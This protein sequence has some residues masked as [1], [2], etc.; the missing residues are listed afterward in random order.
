MTRAEQ[1][2]KLGFTS[3]DDYLASAWWNDF[4][5]AYYRVHRGGCKVCGTRVILQLHHTTYR[6][7]GCESFDDVVPLCKPHHGSVHDWIR[8]HGKSISQTSE[9]ID[10][11]RR[12]WRM[13][14]SLSAV[15]LR[16]RYE[17][18]LSEFTDLMEITGGHVK[19]PHG[20]EP[21]FHN[22]LLVRKYLPKLR[23]A[24]RKMRFLHGTL[25]KDL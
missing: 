16:R 9:A 24:A 11:V 21:S 6:R 13:T 17:K 15:R 14:S 5:L 25:S 20:F 1:L 19:I 23:R 12:G 4:K 22:R 8:V 3:Y 7:L 10:A 18:H 2:M